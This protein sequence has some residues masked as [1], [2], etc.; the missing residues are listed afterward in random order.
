M[1]NVIEF[2]PRRND[3]DYRREIEDLLRS[4]H[5]AFTFQKVDGSIRDMKVTL[6]PSVLPEQINP[7]PSKAKPGILVIWDTENEGWR[8]IRYD[9]VIRFTSLGP[10]NTPKEQVSTW[11]R[12]D[13]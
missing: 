13:T 6:M 3:D 2:E 10:T 5:G 12:T 4:N 1:P 7:N 8:S 9:S 11:D